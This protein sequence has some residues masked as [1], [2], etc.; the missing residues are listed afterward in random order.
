MLPGEDVSVVESDHV[1]V[2]ADPHL[3]PPWLFHRSPGS[4]V[5]VPDAMEL[6]S[7]VRAALEDRVAARSEAGGAE[8][9]WRAVALPLRE[10]DLDDAAPRDGAAEIGLFFLLAPA[11]WTREPLLRL[12]QRTIR[13][14]LRRWRHQRDVSRR[15][16]TDSLTGLHNRAYFDSQFAL[17]L[18]RAKRSDSPL[19]LVLGD[20]DQFK[21]V[22]DRYG[23]LTGD[24]VLR[25]VAR[26]LQD[27]LRRIDHV[28]RIGGEEFALILPHTS[29][30]AAREVMVRL[31]SRP[32][33]VD[34]TAAADQ[35]PLAVTVS[36]G[37]VTYPD[38]G[39]DALELYRKADAMLYLSK[40]AG[41]HLCHVWN[42]AGD[43]VCI[44][45]PAEPAP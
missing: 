11:S 43:P 21:L 27:E 32:V 38:D 18:E 42:D 20:L 12:A 9:S 36:Y 34:G 16:H 19:S 17:E 22:N 26:W 29:R 3:E 37:V 33:V 1:F 31:L 13:F 7:H 10:P 14:V 44:A 35:P 39:S 28:C 8:P 41:R 23:H 45:P 40:E 6:P 15:I 30:Q 4:S 5:W 24:R 25:E 2:A